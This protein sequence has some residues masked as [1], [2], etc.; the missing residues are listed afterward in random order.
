MMLLG[1][2]ILLKGQQ[3]VDPGTS[4]QN[5]ITVGLAN[6]DIVGSDNRAIQAAI[7]MMAARGGGTVHILSGEY[8]LDDALRLRSN[9]RLTG[10]G[11]NNTIL[12][13]APSISSP[14]LKDADTGQKEATPIDVSRFKVGMGI[15]FRSNKYQ[16]EMVTKP[17]TITR[18]ENGVLY[19]NNYIEFDFIADF[20]GSKGEEGGLVA[21]IYPLIFG[22][23]IENATVEGLTVDATVADDPG[24]VDVRS[25]NLVLDRCKSCNIHNVKAVNTRGDGILIITSEHITVEDCEGANNTHHGIHSGSHSPWTVVRRCI[26]HDNG[27]DGIYICWGVRE[28]EFTDN[29]VYHNGFGLIRNGIS[30]GHK[31]TDDLLARNHIYDNAKDGIHF[32]TKTEPNGP[33]RT[34]VIDNLIE[35]NGLAGPKVKGSGIHICGIVHDIIIENNTIRETREGA[36]RLQMNAVFIEQGVSRVKMSNNKISGHPESAIVDNSKSPDNQ[37]QIDLYSVD[38]KK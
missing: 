31:D 5:I 17:F 32:R 6:A 7:D 15:V 16:N 23:E 25:G 3:K 1:Q 36:G 33:H 9:I 27:S 35:N 8:I 28:S 26:V 37:L 20:E 4:G 29:T 34:K 13:H 38:P 19:F 14:L 24:W 2:T 10:D 12:K 21:N 22:Y 18:I 11:L 30:I